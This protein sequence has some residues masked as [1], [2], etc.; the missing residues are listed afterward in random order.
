MYFYLD[1][2]SRGEGKKCKIG[3]WRILW[4]DPHK[5]VDRIPERKEEGILEHADIITIDQILLQKVFEAL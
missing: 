1:I 5:L 3:F 2:K 4:E